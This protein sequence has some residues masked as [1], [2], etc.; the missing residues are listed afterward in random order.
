MS[1]SPRERDILGTIESLLADED[2]VLAAQLTGMRLPEPARPARWMLPLTLL[3]ILGG[4]VLMV[5]AAISDTPIVMV[6]GVGSA[7]IVP[8]VVA[9]WSFRARRRPS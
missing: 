4:I 3:S 1:L 8:I 5:V 2:P 9:V 6:T 7:V